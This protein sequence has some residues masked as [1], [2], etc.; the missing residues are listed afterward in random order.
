MAYDFDD[1]QVYDVVKSNHLPME[2]VTVTPLDEVTPRVL[3][4]VCYLDRQPWPCP[5]VVDLRDYDRRQVRR[6]VAPV[7]GSARGQ[8]LGG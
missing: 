4:L 2:V 5:A 7:D 3:R 6:G 8:R 1:K